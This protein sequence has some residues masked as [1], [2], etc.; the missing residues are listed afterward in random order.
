M[1]SFFAR[2]LQRA[3]EQ[4]DDGVFEKLE[5]I[6]PYLVEVSPQLE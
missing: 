5:V 6:K 3:V 4:K 2:L 1:K